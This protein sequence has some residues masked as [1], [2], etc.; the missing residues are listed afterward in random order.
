M[1]AVVWYAVCVC[2]CVCASES[3]HESL[4]RPALDYSAP[5]RTPRTLCL[6]S[7]ASS[8]LEGSDDGHAALCEYLSGQHCGV[9]KYMCM[10]MI[11]CCRRLGLQSDSI[12]RR[13]IKGVGN[14]CFTELNRMVY[15]ILN[16]EPELS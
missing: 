6:L 14:Q 11:C 5:I 16:T 4:V 10:M 12:E 7:S 2:V 9:G 13:R 8:V 15:R 1:I 3:L